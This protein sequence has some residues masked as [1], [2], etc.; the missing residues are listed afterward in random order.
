MRAIDSA[1]AISEA[2]SW[3][4][5][6]SAQTGAKQI[7]IA[8]PLERCLLSANVLERRDEHTRIVLGGESPGRRRHPAADALMILVDE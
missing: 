3:F 2:A 5:R 4:K 7:R 6:A 1:A 8:Q